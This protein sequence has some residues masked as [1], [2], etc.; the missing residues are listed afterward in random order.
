MKYHALSFHSKHVDW[1]TFGPTE[2]FWRRLCQ[3]PTA[4]LRELSSGLRIILLKKIFTPGGLYLRASLDWKI[5]KTL[6]NVCFIWSVSKIMKGMCPR[7]G[8][9]PGE[10]N[11][12]ITCHDPW[13]GIVVIVRD[14]IHVA[15]VSFHVETDPSSARNTSMKHRAFSL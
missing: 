7:W 10:S 5:V 14:L 13:E 1:M 12:P 3:T 11:K 2:S 6:I 8:A 4:P 15:S 9:C